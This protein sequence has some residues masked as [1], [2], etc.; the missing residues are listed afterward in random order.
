ML[1]LNNN[2]SVTKSASKLA[3]RACV[4]VFLTFILA[5]CSSRDSSSANSSGSTNPDP[6]ADLTYATSEESP[7]VIRFEPANSAASY[8]IVS[9]PEFG[10]VTLEPGNEQFTYLPEKDF[11]GYDRIAYTDGETETVL[12]VL[13]RNVN[14]EPVLFDDVQRVAEQGVLYQFTL[15]AVDPDNDQLVYSAE[16]L[17]AWLSLNTSTGELSG[18]PT[19]QQLGMFTGIAFKVTDPLGEF[20]EIRGISIEVLDI[21]DAPTINP[22]QFPSEI[23]AR[24]NVMVNVFPDDPDG[25]F[26]TI[27]TE[28]NDFLT[29]V[30][31]GGS[32]E[33]TAADVSDVSDINLVV[34]ATDSRGNVAREIIPLTILPLTTST[35]G[36][37]LR[38]RKQGAGVH[39][40]VLG[41]GYRED[42]QGKFR[43]HVDEFIEKLEN[44]DGIAPHFGAWNVHMVESI[45]VDSGIDDDF[46]FDFRDTAYGAGYFCASIQRLICAD[47][48]KVIETAFS[49][50]PDFHQIILIVN[51]TRYG[52]SGGQFSVAS[53]AYPEVSLHELGHSFAGLAD[54]YVDE[55]I[56][57]LSPSSYTEGRY[58]NISKFDDPLVVPW[59][60]WLALED[61]TEVG[62]FE[63]A[64]YQAT[65]FYR[66]TADSRMRSY[67]R[68]FGPVNSEQWALRVYETAKAV[69]DFSP[70]AG[71]LTVPSG[72]EQEFRVVPIL[73]E[74]VQRI[75]WT[76][77][78]KLVPSQTNNRVFTA[79]LSIGDH[80][81]S[82]LVEDITGQ[83]R[84][85]TPH[86]GQFTWNWDI[87]KQ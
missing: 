37:T 9:N 68:P 66:A 65:D 59:A 73:D 7:L 5:S 69:I 42:Q 4:V 78:G 62:I 71:V 25:E 34:I 53:S 3:I 39:L 63:G 87:E 21:N 11:F 80:T 16:N 57:K 43:Q 81:L 33:V 67:N 27:S 26:V 55:T 28:P 46:A 51:D 31:Q 75:T 19:Q 50:Y 13:V 18:T 24:S 44:D 85:P 32:L 64:F 82:V 40:V 86:S 54:E 22:E 72:Q 30:A 41:D 79:P 14:D 29:V 2:K 74:S 60:H 1:D 10:Q 17:P 61:N 45:S 48:L 12:N 52:G 47:S 20:S 35:K 36:V 76:L 49:E 70:V 6:L 83:I 84:K 38:G 58:A 77:D 23:K 15:N 56:P 8:S